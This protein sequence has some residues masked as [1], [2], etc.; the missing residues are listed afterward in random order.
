MTVEDGAGLAIDERRLASIEIVADTNHVVTAGF[1]GVRSRLRRALGRRGV[2]ATPTTERNPLA[3]RFESVLS[4]ADDGEI[5]KFS[6]TKPEVRVDPGRLVENDERPSIWLI[7]LSAETVGSDDHLASVAPVT[8]RDRPIGLADESIPG[9]IGTSVG[10]PGTLRWRT[11]RFVTR[12]FRISVKIKTP[13]VPAVPRLNTARTGGVRS[14]DGPTGWQEAV[15]AAL[16]PHLSG[17]S[18]PR[19]P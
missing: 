11:R 7:Q 1:G 8:L 4:R 6:H 3:A 9:E 17:S 18:S 19:L 16:L 12:P 2:V 13:G 15:A 14:P 5:R 10:K